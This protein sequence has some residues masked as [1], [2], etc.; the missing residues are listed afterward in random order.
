MNGYEPDTLHI[1]AIKTMKVIHAEDSKP[2]PMGGVYSFI[3]LMAAE[4][5][6]T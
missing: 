1:S 5:M 4:I 6:K 3:G 2:A